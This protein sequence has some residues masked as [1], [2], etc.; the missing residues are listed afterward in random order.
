MN[1][2]ITNIPGP[3]IPLYLRGARFLRVFPYVEVIDNE[4]L[5]IAVVSYEDHL[6]F[7]ITADR[8]VMPD[9]GEVAASIER[10][11]AALARRRAPRRPAATAGSAGVSSSAGGR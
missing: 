1:L 4:G 5:T 11:F 10:E 3:P 7:G 6:H 8:D 9:L 2:V